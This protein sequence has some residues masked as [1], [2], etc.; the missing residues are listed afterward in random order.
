MNAPTNTAPQIRSDDPV[1]CRP[2]F[3]DRFISGIGHGF[4]SNDGKQPVDIRSGADD[5]SI[6]RLLAEDERQTSEER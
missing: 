1:L 5:F 3:H 2:G 4:G 6:D